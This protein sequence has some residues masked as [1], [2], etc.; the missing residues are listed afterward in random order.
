MKLRTFLAAF[1]SVLVYACPA[2]AQQVNPRIP[3]AP[4]PMA[5]WTPGSDSVINLTEKEFKDLGL[6]QLTW[7]QY[8]SLENKLTTLEPKHPHLS[9]SFQQSPN[10]PIRVLF[11]THLLSYK[12]LPD[13]SY[14]YK[15]AFMD[16]AQVTSVDKPADSAPEWMQ[17]SPSDILPA[18]TVLVSNREDADVV[19]SVG[20][21]APEVWD[22][23]HGGRLVGALYVVMVWAT[24]HLQAPT[25]IRSERAGQAVFKSSSLNISSLEYMLSGISGAV[26]GW[27]AISTDSLARRDRR[28]REA[29]TGALALFRS[30]R[31]PVNPNSK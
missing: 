19:V 31:Q 4:V 12:E 15:P 25:V 23:P 5:K 20:T 29:V 10:R 11:S 14:Q 3:P 6:D 18:D 7:T 2:A 16:R 13:G 1:L 21:A 28:A 9:C 27:D 8:R 17:A 24:C 26:T 30:L 22:R